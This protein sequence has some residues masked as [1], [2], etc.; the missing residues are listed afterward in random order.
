LLV[1]AALDEARSSVCLHGGMHL[2]RPFPV[3]M[4]L[5]LLA[6]LALAAVALGATYEPHRG[7]DYDFGAGNGTAYL[8]VNNPYN[9]NLSL[10]IIYQIGERKNSTVLNV[11]NT[12]VIAFCGLGHGWLYIQQHTSPLRSPLAL[13]PLA[14]PRYLVLRAGESATITA[15]PL[16]APA[17]AIAVAIFLLVAIALRPK[18]GKWAVYATPEP[19]RSIALWSFNR[20]ILVLSV[21]EILFLLSL[22]FPV[23]PQSDIL[24][25]IRVGLSRFVGHI[26]DVSDSLILELIALVAVYV[27]WSLGGFYLTFHRRHW[28]YVYLSLSII[29]SI[30]LFF[31]SRSLL[32][33][34]VIIF[35]IT[36]VLSSSIILILL[37]GVFMSF[38]L[39]V[40]G[41]SI[42]IYYDMNFGLTASWNLPF[43]IPAIG[44]EFWIITFPLLAVFVVYALLFTR[45]IFDAVAKLKSEDTATFYP[46]LLPPL[47]WWFGLGI[48]ALSELTVRS[49]LH[50]LSTSRTITVDLSRGR[51][52]VVV[53]A[54]LYGM[55]LCKYRGATCDDVE[56]VRYGEVKFK[57]SSRIKEDARDRGI[58]D[59]F[60]R[61][62][63][64]PIFAG[65][66]AFCVLKCTSIYTILSFILFLGE[67]LRIYYK[68]GY[69]R[70]MKEYIRAIMRDKGKIHLRIYTYLIFLALLTL[71][72]LWISGLVTVSALIVIGDV[73]FT[74]IIVLFLLRADPELSKYLFPWLE[75]RLMSAGG[76]VIGLARGG[77]LQWAKV[78]VA[79]LGRAFV[80]RDEDC[81][82]VVSPYVDNVRCRLQR[83]LCGP[84][85]PPVRVV[86]DEELQDMM[87]TRQPHS[88][89]KQ[90]QDVDWRRVAV[91]ILN[92]R[93]RR[94]YYYI[95]DFPR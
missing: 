91:G 87:N 70:E 94:Y 95:V 22:F 41:A 38:L 57:V 64:L 30:L 84:A 20:F 3:D 77:C 47:W 52:A 17:T 19:L 25:I 29:I 48:F 81:E 54:D 11:L 46:A 61:K 2:Y 32:F 31:I 78:G 69:L 74:A 42:F 60:S 39:L 12:R 13:Y 45:I 59:R 73:I 8:V 1:A 58:R 27:I 43:Q 33:L 62:V 4:R 63:V 93:K 56:W 88:H 7:C 34:L 65:I 16:F 44:A 66:L 24:E 53:S 37:Y 15:G 26:S 76:L 9:L 51:R 89:K 75:L 92:L 85:C 90:V 55:Y 72:L 36:S 67:S 21:I 35:S 71:N 18:L 86:V 23:E 28:I 10:I 40:Y 83:Y 79:P 68:Y 49:F 6:V 50:R 14:V 5:L 80:I 82:V